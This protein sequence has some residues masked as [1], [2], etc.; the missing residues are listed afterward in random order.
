MLQELIRDCQG[1]IGIKSESGQEREVAAFLKGIML[2]L[3]YDEAIDDEYGS[4]IGI[5][6]G[7]GG[8]KILLEGHLDTVGVENP[9]LWSYNPYA[10]M[11]DG[12]RLYGRGATDMK[13]ALMAMT[14]AA[15]SFIGT[16][17]QLNGDI[18]VAGVVQE[19]IFE[20]VAQG[21][22]LDRIHPDLVILGEATDLKLCIGQRGRAELQIVTYG[23]SA[24]SANP[25]AGI[26]AV[27]L[28]MQLL[29]EKDRMVLPVD[30]FLGPAIME[31]TDIHSDPYPGKSVLPEKCTV[32]LDRRLLP[33]ETE[34]SVLLPIQKLI[35]QLTRDNKGFKA[36]VKVVAATEH[37]YTGA[38]IFG[39][40]FFPGWLYPETASFVL[41]AQT[42]LHKAG[43]AA[44]L[45][46]YSFCTDGSQSAGIRRIPT[47]G[48][49]PSRE[50]I[51]HI[52]NEYV[53]LEQVKRAHDGYVC[54]IRDF[55]K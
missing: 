45:S 4:V 22:I 33:G 49:G 40:R 16:K 6:H 39:K 13:A 51:A 2:R 3:G 25:S 29:V 52:T 21:K 10:G 46:H 14:Y 47:L 12:G 44:P 42:A 19:E 55:L 9:D 23:K 1:M 8:K 15:S 34:D 5:I 38:E 48:F 36:E 11:C 35:D 54:L 37:C 32:T 27:G 18:I 26:N 31:L 41:S 53:E 43:Y 7:N 30:S 24:H 20:G 17:E 28:M 50:E